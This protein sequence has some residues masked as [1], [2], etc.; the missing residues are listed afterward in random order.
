[1]LLLS[2]QERDITSFMKP[3]FMLMYQISTDFKRVCILYGMKPSMNKTLA[4]THQNVMRKTR[5]HNLKWS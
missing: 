2:K 4:Q 5:D 1:M 3:V